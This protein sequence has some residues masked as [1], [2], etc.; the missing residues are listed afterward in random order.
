MSSAGKQLS[1]PYSTG[2]GGVNFETRVQALFAVLMLTGGFAPCL[3]SWPIKKIKLQ[4]KYAG[5][6][7]DDFIAFVSDWNTEK[8]VKLLAQIKHSISITEGDTIF[9]E[10]IHAAW[11]DFCNPSL[12]TQGKDV[13][14]LITGPLSATDIDSARR[15]LELARDSEDSSDFTT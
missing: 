10:V 4:G 11:R 5:Y 14:A 12:F 2:G 13:I 1:N 8:E 6:E 7:T 15:I 3:P 9:G